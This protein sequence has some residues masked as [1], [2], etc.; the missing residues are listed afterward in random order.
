MWEY[1]IGGFIY[2]SPAIGADGTIYIGS[3]DTQLYAVNTDGSLKWTF[4]TGGYVYGSPV[5]GKDGT[6]YFGSYDSK[7]YALNPD[8]SKKWEFLTNDR[9]FGSPAIGCDGTVYISSSDRK[10]YALNPD[11]TKKWEYLTNNNIYW[12]TPS[13][14]NDG[15]VYTCNVGGSVYAINPDG[16]KKWEFVTGGAVYSSPAIDNDGTIYV[17]S[18]D[19]KAYAINPDGTK[20]WD[21][22]TSNAI[23][24]SPSIGNDGTVYI[25]SLDRS[26]YALNTDG[27]QK[28]VFP[29]NSGI[30]SSPVLGSDGTIYIGSTDNK[31]YALNPDGTKQWEY[32]T[33]GQI[34]SIPNIADDGTVYIGSFDNKLYA[35]E[36]ASM[37]LG[38][39]PWPK[40]GS[41]VRNTSSIEMMTPVNLDLE[42]SLETGIVTLSWEDLSLEET[43]YEIEFSVDGGAFAMTGETGADELSYQHEN[44]V[45][46]VMEYRVRAVYPYGKS[47]YSNSAELI[48]QGV[49]GYLVPNDVI[50]GRCKVYVRTAG[51]GLNAEDLYITVD[52]DATQY[53]MESITDGFQSGTAFNDR[54]FA[55]TAATVKVWLNGDLYD[56]MNM[57]EGGLYPGAQL[58]FDGMRF[59]SDSGGVRAMLYETE[60]GLEIPEN[61]VKAFSVKI[62][63]GGVLNIE[64]TLGQSGA[65]LHY[66]DGEWVCVSY[67]KE[68]LVFDQDG[69]YAVV[70]DTAGTYIPRITGSVL[71]Q[72]YP[73][74][75][76]P[77]TDIDFELEEGGRV[78]LEIF[79]SRG[80]KIV[81]L[82]DGV[83]M[84]GIHSVHWN[85]RDA[86]GHECASGVYY[87]RMTLNGKGYTK[88]MVMLK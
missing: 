3:Y 45:P 14:A 31:V 46:G 81:I 16:T 34:Y 84:S 52:D 38:D 40:F 33:G 9:I 11:G 68:A 8:G 21:F 86:R 74:P 76:N 58:S 88:K 27:S 42:Y 83:Y 63:G 77:E 26:L 72:N 23:Y 1:A 19:H 47:E 41:N 87:C 60:Q 28:W 55:D 24:S 65:L 36:S 66:E 35:L 82:A 39:T 18:Y 56:T 29:T 44:S 51:P 49:Y 71:K 17:G 78:K 73:N 2:S 5:I 59:S 25:A 69:A 6:I 30:Y 50:W 15:T 10:I 48:I 13:V 79:D 70:N 20:K 37:G 80:R 67:G 85:G 43:G 53:A 22:T 4:G 62:D 7:F 61:T 32:Q 75:F 12:T 64:N 54:T 57:T